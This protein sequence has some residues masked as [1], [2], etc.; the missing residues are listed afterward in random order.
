M[1]LARSTC[2]LFEADAIHGN[3][4]VCHYRCNGSE[5]QINAPYFLRAIDIGLTLAHDAMPCAGR[6]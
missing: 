6:R 5:L 1:R 3:S 4:K 2:C